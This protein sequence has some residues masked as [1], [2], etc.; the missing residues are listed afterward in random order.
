MNQEEKFIFSTSNQLQTL[1]KLVA[2]YV[3]KQVLQNFSNNNT[4]MLKLKEEKKKKRKERN[5]LKFKLI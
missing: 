2:T 3:T 5:N 1:I 4:T